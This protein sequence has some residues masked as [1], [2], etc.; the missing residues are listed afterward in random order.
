M[1]YIFKIKCEGISCYVISLQFHHSV[2]EGG[3]GMEA[4]V[5]IKFIKINKDD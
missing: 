3:R 5:F 1:S 4:N 2:Q